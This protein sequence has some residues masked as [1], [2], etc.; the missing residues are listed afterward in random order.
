[1]SGRSGSLSLIPESG[2]RSKES[3]NNP[4]VLQSYVT[5][6]TLAGA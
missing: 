6:D 1:V 3:K 2:N 5:Y 4:G